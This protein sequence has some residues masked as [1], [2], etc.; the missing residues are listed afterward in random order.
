MR[1]VKIYP[2]V[3]GSMQVRLI[4]AG[5]GQPDLRHLRHALSK[6]DIGLSKDHDPRDP[7]PTLVY[8]MDASAELLPTIRRI[9]A[10]SGSQVLAVAGPGASLTTQLTW[11]LVRTG[12]SDVLTWDSCDDP[13][14]AVVSRLERWREVDELLSS[15]AITRSLVGTG[16]RWKRLLRQIVEVAR[17]TR[18]SILLTGESGTGKDFVAHIIHDLDNRSKKKDLTV[19]DCATVVPSLS[20]SEF[21][22][23]EKGAFT[24]AVGPR[25]GAFALANGGTLFLDEIGELPL[26]L[27][28]ELLRVIQEGTYKRVGSNTW[29]TT[30]FRLVSATN[31]DL[32]ADQK[33]G[34]FRLDLYYR[35]AAWQFRL[36]PL[37]ER[38]EDIE[39]LVRTLFA[40]SRADGTVPDFDPA[41]LWLLLETP[42]LERHLLARH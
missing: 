25:D 33:A 19:L 40:R 3:R 10:M 11:E 6:A 9:S 17:F 26:N 38:R 2:E 29:H 14:D 15:E 1:S 8:F 28:A 36:P 35:I 21:F 30:D 20:G 5:S 13:A 31:R 41:A 24:G 23:H 16:A 12:A 37:R 18:A 22:G 4:T 27:Q 7:G 32:A 34:R 42:D 39:P